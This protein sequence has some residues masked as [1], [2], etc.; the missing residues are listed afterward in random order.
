M[1]YISSDYVFPGR[2]G[3]A[4]YAEDAAPE[5]PNLYGQTKLAGERA[6]L[7]VLG[8]KRL[9][10][11]LRIPVLYGEGEVKE[12][13][14][15]V[16]QEVVLGAVSARENGSMEQKAVD[17]WSVRYPTNTEDVARVLKDMAEMYTSKS[18]EQRRDLPS[19]LHFSGQ[20]RFTKFGICEV[21]AEILGVGAEGLRAD[22][23]EPK[24]GPGQ[25]PRPYD[26]HLGTERL[27][28]LGISVAAQD[29]E[30]WWKRRLGAYRH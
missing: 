21:F 16:L 8:E 28:E 23:A 29:F 27:R 18:E 9:G 6:V 13:S 26:C 11:S 24:V 5:P 10:V 2:K 15:N 7:E 19:V 3:E 4:P 20:E 14:I 12:S 17:D 22:S 25:A 1:I 30:G